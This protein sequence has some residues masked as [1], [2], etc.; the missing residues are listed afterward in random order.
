MKT[1]VIPVLMLLST[2]LLGQKDINLNLVHNYNGAPFSYGTT[3]ST[4]G[5]TAVSFDRVQYYLSGFEITHDGGQTLSMPD[6]YVLASGNITG[7]NVGNEA[8]TTVEGLSFDLGVDNVANHM[9]LSSWPPGHPLSAQSPSMDWSWPSGYFFFVIDGLIDDTGDGTPNKLF[10]LRGL[11]DVLLR[12]VNDFTGLSLSGG[13]IE[14]A[15]DANIA[16]WI[17]NIDL[18]TVGAD[19]SSS[20]NNVKVADNTNDE[21]VFTISPLLDV[22]HLELKESKIYANYELPYAPTIFYNLNTKSPV[23]IKVFGLDGKLY[24]ESN[25]ESNEGNFF[26]NKELSTGTY[27]IIFSN[28]EIEESFKFAVKK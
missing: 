23:D 1:I 21:T 6:S 15:V 4:S 20:P 7:Y 3:Y 18:A 8:V 2:A 5:G 17:M 10:Q 12:D 16:D 28:S 11:G 24:I 14:L 27:L 9:G 22:E 26:I 19:H 25:S 13:S